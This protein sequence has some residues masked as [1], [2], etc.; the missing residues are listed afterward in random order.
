MKCSLAV[1]I[2]SNCVCQVLER[3]LAVF[4]FFAALGRRTQRF[5]IANNCGDSDETI[6]DLLR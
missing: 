2:T 3:D 4:G 5:L 1:K 6:A